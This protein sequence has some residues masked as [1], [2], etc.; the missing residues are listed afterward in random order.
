MS[1]NDPEPIKCPSCGAPHRKHVGLWDSEVKCEYCGAVFLVHREKSPQKE[2]K[3]DFESK[4]RAFKDAF[5]HTGG[6]E[7]YPAQSESPSRIKDYFWRVAIGM[8][9]ATFFIF[10]FAV[11]SIDAFVRQDSLKPILFIL[12]S[13]PFW[14]ILYVLYRFLP[15]DQG[16]YRAPEYK[17]D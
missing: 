2:E 3:E 10:L 16:K 6:E 11:L 1:K 12:L 8:L 4:V 7:Q 17:G 14:A 13:S 9:V 5:D 15:K